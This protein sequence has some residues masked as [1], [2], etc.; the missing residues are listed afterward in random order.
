MKIDKSINM[1][2]WNAVEKTDK[3]FTKQINIG[4]KFTA[5]NA[6][7]QIKTATEY[8][9][10]IG[11]GWGVKNESFTIICEGLLG[12]QAIFWY[13]IG[14]L[15]YEY[16]IN[17]SIA[18][19]SRAGKLDED[20]YKKVST[21]ALTKGLSKL[22][23]N[24]DV[25]LGRFDAQKYI[26]DT[27]GQETVKKSLKSVKKPIKEEP[28]EMTQKILNHMLEYVSKGKIKDVQDALH[29]YKL[30]EK[31]QV[32]IDFAIANCARAY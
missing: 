7:Y 14:D 19:H 6:Q 17:S 26:N 15:C 16:S 27:D 4:R 22:G 30:T 29:K 8:L 2:L 32:T 25:F 10:P 3:K 20:V 24:A 1:Q 13:K 28:Q 9:G 11:D 21:D 12:Y 31:Q 18:T 23:F 5:I